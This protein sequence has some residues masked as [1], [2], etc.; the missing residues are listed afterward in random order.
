MA[1]IT[2][3]VGGWLEVKSCTEEIVAKLGNQLKH[4]YEFPYDHAKKA[5]ELKRFAHIETLAS[6]L[7]DFTTEKLKSIEKDTNHSNKQINFVGYSQG[8]MVIYYALG[9]Y[10]NLRKRT[11]KIATIA[12]PHGGAFI[13][14]IRDAFWSVIEKTKSW[15]LSFS[16]PLGPLTASAIELAEHITGA[17]QLLDHDSSEFIRNEYPRLCKKVFESISPRNIMEIYSRID[18]VAPTSSAA[19]FSDY[20][21]IE[22]VDIPVHQK[23]ANNPNVQE[24]ILSFLKDE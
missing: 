22:V 16:N 12:T 18:V 8:G 5:L 20:M 9:K 1:K 24:K 2:V 15:F 13:E 23:I 19:K 21:K 10:P 6:R 7:F 3:F 4:F 17:R 14:E 11:N